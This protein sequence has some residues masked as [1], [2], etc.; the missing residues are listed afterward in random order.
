MFKTKF[1]IIPFLRLVNAQFHFYEMKLEFSL[2]QI[3]KVKGIS[4]SGGK[5][6]VGV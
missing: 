6:A 3:C 4:L 1:R 2:L 5:G